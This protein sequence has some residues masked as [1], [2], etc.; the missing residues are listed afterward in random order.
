YA[1]YML[2]KQGSVTSWNSG[3]TRITGYTADEILGS[4]FARFFT[5][6]DQDVDLPMATLHAAALE[7]RYEGEG[8]RVRAD[9]SSF[10]A[11]T[12]VEPVRNALGNLLGFAVVTRD[13]TEKRE[14]ALAL[15][16]ARE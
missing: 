15:K 6:S 14:S 10:W 16:R 9:R 7:G 2:S 4:H 13:I 12:A 1:I 5:E 11:H 8:W 3:A